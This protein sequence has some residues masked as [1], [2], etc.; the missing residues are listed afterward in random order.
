MLKTYFKVAIRNL[1]K[2]RRYTLINITGLSVGL[3]SCVLIV[4][5][6]RD[7]LSFDKHFDNSEKIYRVTGA[8]N[9]GGETKTHSALV[10]YPLMPVLAAQFPEMEA[11]TRIDQ[12]SGLLSRGDQ[13]IWQDYMMVADSTFFNLFSYKAIAG[14][15]Q[16][17]LLDPRSIVMTE[18]AADRH[19][20]D[21]EPLGQVVTFMETDF[22][23]AAIVED[24]PDNTHFQAE[25]FLPLAGAIDFYGDW[26]HYLFNGTSHYLYFRLQEGREAADLE[27]RVNAFLNDTY[28]RE[29]GE[30]Q[31]FL[32]PLEDIH[33]QS[34]LTGELGANGNRI[35]VL[36]FIATAVVIL[37]LA[38][39]NYINLSIAGSFQRSR[40]VGLKKI[41]GARSLSQLLQFQAE[42][43]IIALISCVLAVILVELTFPMFNE[44]TGKSL[45]FVIA[46]D[47]LLGLGLFT[48]AVIIGLVSGSF[49]AL[50]LLKMNTSD[51][52]KGNAMNKGASRFNFRNGLI[53]FQFTIAVIL[54]ASTFVI[55]RQIN[56]IRNMD[57]GIDTE[58]VLVIPM[59]TG[60]IATNYDIIREELLRKPTV[61]NVTGSNNHPASRISNWRGY[62]P[63]GADKNIYAPTVIITHDF[64][65]TMGAEMLEGRAFSRDFATD[66]TEAYVIN[67]S[68]VKFFEMEEPIGA[69]L[70][71]LAYTGSEWSWKNAKIVGVV[72]DFHFASLHSEIRPA[73]F[74][75]S[76][77]ATIGLR[78][79]N[80]KI[81][82]ENIQ[83]TIAHLETV[84]KQHEPEHPFQYA[85]MDEEIN[86]HYQAEDRFLKVFTGFS[87]ISVVIGCLGLFGLTAFMMRRRTKEIGIRK[88][89]GAK[90]GGLV[91]LL[92]RDF[93]KLV[94]LANL[95]G[96]PAAYYLMDEWLG[97]F[98]YAQEITV[99]TFAITGGL[100]TLIAFASIAFHSVKTARANPVDSI[101]YE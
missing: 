44:L 97:N 79:I 84:W 57:L 99:W 88:V 92:S 96:W 3:A 25:V 52:L 76:S 19:F 40:E 85:F 47:I 31:Y 42:S 38:C 50:F 58:Q 53:V 43:I 69:D 2:N 13:H 20:G 60:N 80:V 30:H 35:T 83:E 65:E 81:A 15:P 18:K 74:S 67:E 71:G 14:D 8:Y 87:F 16:A 27:A 59:Q 22:K 56:Y 28:Q 54:I 10:T 72:K 51:A 39:I 101:R 5:F 9:Q 4:L 48:T 73:V 68:A 12:W 41:F 7:E 23:V 46:Q 37:L 61:L 93:L 77:Q 49:P 33:L 21:E 95:L 94:L 26:V 62:R 75:L 6:V 34:D 1:W 70:R 24:T 63:T 78:Y 90:V 82:P 98:A 89:L 66:Y 32:Q 64:F 17:T 45:D 100:A 86:D 36:I 11:P 91:S 29:D 55:L